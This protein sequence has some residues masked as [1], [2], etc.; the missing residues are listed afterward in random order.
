MSAE[1]EAKMRRLKEM[2]DAKF[3]RPKRLMLSVDEEPIS[4]ALGFQFQLARRADDIP[5]EMTFARFKEM[6]E[7]GI[8]PFLNR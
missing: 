4:R 1:I 5:R 7:N 2:L 3:A 8:D 6:R